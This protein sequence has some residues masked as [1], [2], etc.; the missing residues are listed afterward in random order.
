MDESEPEGQT[1]AKKH[2]ISLDEDARWK[3]LCD[4]TALVLATF[5]IFVYIFWA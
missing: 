2:T 4:A 3:R 1:A 5:G